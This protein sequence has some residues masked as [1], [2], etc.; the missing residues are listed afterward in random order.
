M[1]PNTSISK[2]GL[3]LLERVGNTPLLRLE[4]FSHWLGDHGAMIYAKAEFMNPGGSVKDRAARGMI[5]GAIKSGELTKD[6]IILDSSSGNTGISYA[7]IG[8][9]L[10]YRVELCI[11]ENARAK[12]RVSEAYGAQVIYTDPLE[13]S[14]GAII[15]AQEMLKANPNR[16]YMPDQYNNPNNWR[17]HYETTAEEIWAQTEGRV[18]HFVTGIGTSG[19]LMGTGRRLKELNPKIQIVA[20]EPYSALH[21][22]EGL[23]H[24]ASSIVPGIY[25]EKVHDRKVSVHTEDAYEMCCRLAREEGILAGFSSGAALQGAFEV[26]LGVPNAVVV[27]I[28][29]DSGERY[30]NSRFWEEMINYFEQYWRTHDPLKAPRSR[31][32]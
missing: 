3:G 7:M 19:T 30:I 24:M 1:T 29:A 22:L 8:T 31:I 20:V 25:D 28:I 32:Q 27:T 9:A 13:G 18:T 6:K 12:A 11:P 10:G 23:K 16:Y 14:D 17:A 15:K 21:G 26:A 4:R 2:I 5:M